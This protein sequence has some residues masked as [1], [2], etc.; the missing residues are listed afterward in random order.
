M[1]CYYAATCIKVMNNHASLHSWG[2]SSFL[3]IAGELTCL[4]LPIFF[5]FEKDLATKQDEEDFIDCICTH[6]FMFNTFTL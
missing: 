2:F 6:R 5:T 3:Q 1:D 4:S